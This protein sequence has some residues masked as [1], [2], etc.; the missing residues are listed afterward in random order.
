MKEYSLVREFMKKMNGGK[1]KNGGYLSLRSVII[2]SE[3]EI[4]VSN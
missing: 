1:E 3:A 4:W 2:I